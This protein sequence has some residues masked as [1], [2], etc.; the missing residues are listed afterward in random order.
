MQA[1]RSTWGNI[2][3]AI[4]LLVLLLAVM[5][6][7]SFYEP[8]MPYWKNR[9]PAVMECLDEGRYSDALAAA[10]VGDVPGDDTEYWQ[11]SEPLGEVARGGKAA[12]VKKAAPV[13]EA[14]P[15]EEAAPEKEPTPVD[16]AEPVE[17]PVSDM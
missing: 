4:L 1:T 5:A 9:F 3:R 7:F 13:E 11:R 6:L 8:L 14:A 10:M 17:E 2:M 15:A 12:P 16:T